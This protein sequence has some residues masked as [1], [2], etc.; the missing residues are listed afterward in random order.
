MPTPLDQVLD[1]IAER[2]PLV[3]EIL[4]MLLRGKVPVS[5]MLDEMADR[6]SSKELASVIAELSLEILRLN[7]ALEE[8]K[9]NRE[10][11]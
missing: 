4:R 10:R 5:T 8:I 2:N 9:T 3:A 6:A 11:D 7:L 1:V